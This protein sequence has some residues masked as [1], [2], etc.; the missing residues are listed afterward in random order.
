MLLSNA[1]SFCPPWLMTQYMYGSYLN[2]FP[3]KLSLVSEGLLALNGYSHCIFS[4]RAYSFK[5]NH[6]TYK[7]KQG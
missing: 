3:M 6:D 4:K 7:E 1:Y 5:K 2:I